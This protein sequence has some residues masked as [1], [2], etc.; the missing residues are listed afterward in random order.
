MLYLPL[1]LSG[2]PP[3]QIRWTDEGLFYLQSYQVKVLE[4]KQCAECLQQKDKP[5]TSANNPNPTT[6]E[7]QIEWT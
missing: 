7:D 6:R 4:S 1:K 3:D 2:T 5:Q